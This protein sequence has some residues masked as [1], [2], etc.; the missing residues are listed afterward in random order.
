MADWGMQVSLNIKNPE[1][2]RLA[3]ELR[4][5]TGE[6]VTAAVITAMRERVERLR[7]ARRQAEDLTMAE[8]LLAIGQEIA[9]RLGEEYRVAAGDHGRLLYDDMGLP[10]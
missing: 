6:S 7:Q 4:A 8:D 1:A 9:D 3:A 10:K 2:D 5:L